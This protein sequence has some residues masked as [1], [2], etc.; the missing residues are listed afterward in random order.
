MVDPMSAKGLTPA[1]KQIADARRQARNES[2]QAPFRQQLRGLGYR[3]SKSAGNVREEYHF[4]LEAGGSRKWRFDFAF[5]A[6]RIAIELEGGTRNNGAHVRHDGYRKDCEKYN[7]ATL[8]GWRV[9]R[10]TSDMV[11]EGSLL[12]VLEEALKGGR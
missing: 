11:S 2:N 6:E 1:E 4:D 3:S 10:G 7:A 5:L 8:Q 9:I 12:L